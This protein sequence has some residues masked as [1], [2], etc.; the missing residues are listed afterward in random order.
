MKQKQEFEKALWDLYN[1]S[2]PLSPKWEAELAKYGSNGY[3]LTYMDPYEPEPVT[4]TI[5][6][7]SSLSTPTSPGL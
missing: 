2:W 5:Y 6:H 7:Q 1:F 3:S 4:I